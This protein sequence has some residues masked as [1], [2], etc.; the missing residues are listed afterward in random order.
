MQQF[1]DRS[2][3]LEQKFKLAPHKPEEE[4][5]LEDNYLFSIKAKMELLSNYDWF[6]YA[7]L[8]ANDMNINCFI[9]LDYEESKFNY[10][11]QLIQEEKS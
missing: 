7:N 6:F 3:R 9:L 10:Q 5:E 1:D 4:A 2:H 8:W 11:L